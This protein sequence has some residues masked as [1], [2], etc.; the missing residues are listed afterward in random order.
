MKIKH[1]LRQHLVACLLF[2]GLFLQSCNG[3]SIQPILQE[4]Q[5]KEKIDYTNKQTSII[6][7]EFFAEKGCLVT[8]HE[9]D[10]ILQAGV[11]T[12][13]SQKGTNM[14]LDLLINPLL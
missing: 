14:Q 10:G 4:Y 6:D 13:G 1:N 9:H 12:D 7:Q 5:L 2:I 8:F 11:K 3:S